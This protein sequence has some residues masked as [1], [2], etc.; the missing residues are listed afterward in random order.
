MS[1][2]QGLGLPPKAF[3]GVEQQKLLDTAGERGPDFRD[4]MMISMAL[5]TALREHEI[6]ALNVGDF[7]RGDTARKR[8]PLRVY[9]RT[10]T[11]DVARQEVVLS[12]TLRAKLERYYGWKRRNDEPLDPEAPLL[13]SDKGNRLSTR[14]MRRRIHEWQE[15][16]GFD[17][18]LGF[19]ALRHAAGIN[20]YRKWKDIVL[21]QRFMRH[22]DIRSTMIYMH[23]SDE[24]FFASVE[25]LRC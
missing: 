7:M 19:H 15:E 24:D 2:V 16:A 23:A 5:A 9:K 12:R 6:A 18:R 22:A 11:A 4:H 1:Y 20:H 10:A 8:V 14:Q 13:W 3:T 21:T 17:R 25:P